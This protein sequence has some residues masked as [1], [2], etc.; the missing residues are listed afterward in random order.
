MERDDSKQSGSQISSDQ[1]G[2]S[3]QG[4]IVVLNNVIDTAG[5]GAPL[6]PYAAPGGSRDS[7]LIGSAA[8]YLPAAAS[9]AVPASSTRERLA[10]GTSPEVNTASSV[11]QG[12]GQ[13]SGG[14]SSSGRHVALIADVMRRSNSNS[15]SNTS[16]KAEDRFL[17]VSPNSRNGTSDEM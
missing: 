10:I 4:T 3:R 16:N 11:Q 9:F 17:S 2:N 12:S 13:H 7:P 14:S 1:S 6:G 8:D 5:G 15:N